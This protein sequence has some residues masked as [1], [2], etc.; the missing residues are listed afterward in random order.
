[1][2]CHHPRRVYSKVGCWLFCGTI[3]FSVVVLPCLPLAMAASPRHSIKAQRPTTHPS[4]LTSDGT[5]LGFLQKM[6]TATE[7]TRF[8]RFPSPPSES[9]G[10]TRSA[11]VNGK[12]GYLSALNKSVGV[13]RSGSL[14]LVETGAEFQKGNGASMPGRQ[15]LL[16]CRDRR[17]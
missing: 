16:P 4:E 7:Y 14:G 3:S 11:R 10:N 17:G 5:P 13:R 8:G 9:T 15:P 12:E 1:M 6:P 2:R